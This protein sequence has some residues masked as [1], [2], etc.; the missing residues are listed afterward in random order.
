MDVHKMKRFIKKIIANH[1]LQSHGDT[2][3]EVMISMAV[4]A[5]VVAAAYA[6]STRAFDASLNSQS[7]DQGVSYAQQQ[8]ELIKE[9][10]N[11]LPSTISTFTSSPGTPFCI[12]SSNKTRKSVSSGNCTVNSQYRV[13][14]TYNNSAQEF[15]VTTTWDSATN[16]P[17][18]AI[19]FYKPNDSFVGA[20]T[21]CTPTTCAS[22]LT[23]PP[24]VGVSATKGTI[25]VGDTDTINWS[26]INVKPGSCTAS[27]PGGFG[28]ADANLNPGTFN[29]TALNTIGTN[30]FTINC[31][32]TVNNPASGSTSVTVINPVPSA[33]TGAASSITYNSATL[34]GSVNPNGFATTYVFNYGTTSTYGSTTGAVSAGAGSSS[35][36][37]ATGI[38]GLSASTLYHFRICATNAYGTT[39]GSDNTFTTANNPPPIVNYFYASPSSI[40][41]G[42]STTLYWGST[43]ATSCT[44]GPPTGATGTGALY[45]T[46]TYGLNCSGPGGSVGTYYATVSV[47]PPPPPPPPCSAWASGSNISGSQALIS[48]GG[49]SCDYFY[50]S[51]V[52]WNGGG[53]WGPTGR[54]VC[55]TQSGG[56][57]PWGWLS[58]GSWCSG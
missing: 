47:D 58:S 36:S 46:T 24:S 15:Q 17:Q 7:R 8:L 35:I 44:Y 25:N 41:Y 4:L 16:L 6:T 31:T 53:T 26:T 5:V 55:H 3:V 33:T 2:I 51:I 39:C 56:A 29:T 40:G 30:T 19:L 23:N 13:A 32:D 49:S 52:G 42:G 21:L 54:P 14:V 1:N 48:G 22:T 34:N 20:P 45:S 50:D 38:G 37:A 43:Y 11:S 18:Q 57:D 27:G 10:D 12:D 9:A 28:G